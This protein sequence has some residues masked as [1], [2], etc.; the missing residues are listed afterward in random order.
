MTVSWSV[1][2]QKERMVQDICRC[3]SLIWHKTSQQR[4]RRKDKQWQLNVFVLVHMK[5][6]C[7]V[8]PQ[9]CNMK[10]E[11]P[12]QFVVSRTKQH[13]NLQVNG[14]LHY[15]GTLLTWTHL[16]LGHFIKQIHHVTASSILQMISNLEVSHCWHVTIFNTKCVQIRTMYH[17]AKFNIPSSNA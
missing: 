17:L 16:K 1:T 2:H 6:C 13:R 7:K 14:R 12:V 10:Q 3:L 9:C 5:M 4:A 8:Y 11:D 15:W